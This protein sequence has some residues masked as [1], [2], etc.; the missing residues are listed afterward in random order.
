MSTP[1]DDT[2][3]QVALRIRPQNA[4][5][6]IDL[7]HICTSVT[8]GH[9]QVVLGKDKAFTYDFV[10]D[11]DSHQE[12]IY[13]EIAKP[14]IEGCF[15][16]Y[17]ATILAYGQTGS[18]KT[19]TMGTSF[20]VGISE[21]Q[22]GII[23][24]AAK[25]LFD[26]IRKRK[27]E[28][29]KAGQP[30]PEFTVTAQFLE[31]YN[32]EI[33]D[34]LD[35]ENKGKKLIRVHEDHNGNIYLTGV[36]ARPVTAAETCMTLLEEG[37]ISRS[38]A[39]TMMNATSSR[40]H[41]IFTLFIKHHRISQS[42]EGEEFETLNAKFNFVDLAGSERLKRTGATGDRAKEGISINQGLL[43]LGNVISALGDK[44][45]R[46]SHV[47]YRDSK[48]TRLL[49]DSLGGNS[50]T[51]M[52]ACCSPSDRDFMETLNT[53]KYANRARNIKNKVIVNQDKA[54]KQ[55]AL[56][57]QE[58]QQITLELMEYKQGKRV[59]DGSGEHMSDTFQELNMLRSENE[60][61]RMR[62]KA[63]QKNIESKSIQLTELKISSVLANLTDEEKTTF[64]DMV[65]SYETKI[66]EL[67]TKLAESEEL[68]SVAIRRAQNVSR[69][70]MSPG[71]CQ[72]DEQLVSFIDAAKDHLRAEKN[73]KKHMKKVKKE[74]LFEDSKE[75]LSPESGVVMN[76]DEND[77][78]ENDEKN[79][80]NMVIEINECHIDEED[81]HNE[82]E[83][84]DIA[85]NTDSDNE[86]A[87]NQSLK[88]E[89]AMQNNINDLDTDIT[90]KQKLIDELEHSQQRLTALKQ[91]YEQK[92]ILLQNKI[93]ETE[94]ERD[95][96]LKS[97]GNVDQL[98][99]SKSDE[100]R[101]QYEKKLIAMQKEL[102]KLQ[103]S[104]REHQ[105]LLKAKEQNEQQLKLMRDE[106]NDMKRTKVKLMRAM[107][108]ESTRNKKMESKFNQQ[109]ET[110][111]KENRKKEYELK[112]MKDD[113]KQRDLILKRKQEELNAMR[114]QVKPVSGKVQSSGQTRPNSL[115]TQFQS[116]TN[117]NTTFLVETITTSIPE[118]PPSVLH[119]P[120][121]F[122]SPSKSL[123]SP[124]VSKKAKQKWEILERKLT[125]LAI[126]MKN[127]AQMENDME[128][129]LA[130]RDR[131]SK[132][133]DAARRRKEI[134]EKKNNLEDIKDLNSQLE[135]LEAHLDY[136]QEHVTE[137]QGTIMGME[138]EGEGIN[139]ADVIN[140][141]TL[142]E[143]KYLLEHFYSKSV[144][145]AQEL[146]NKDAAYKEIQIK[147]EAMEKHCEVQQQLLQ[148]ACNLEHGGDI[149]DA[150]DIEEPLPDF[151]VPTTR[152]SRRK[153]A[154]PEE[155]LHP[156][157]KKQENKNDTEENKENIQTIDR[158][159][160]IAETFQL[161]EKTLQK[162]VEL[163]KS[164]KDKKKMP[165]PPAPT[166]LNSQMRSGSLSESIDDDFS[167]VG[168]F[169]RNTKISK[170]AR[171]F[172][173]SSS[174]SNLKAAVA[175]R[176]SSTRGSPINERKIVGDATPSSLL[177]SESNDVFKRLTSNL[178]TEG[179]P[180][181]GQ[182]L[183]SK[184][185]Q[186][187]PE[188]L[189]CMYTATGHNNAVL[190]LDVQDNLMVSGS[191][192]RT[193]KVWDLT[194]NEEIL[195]LNQ[196][197]RDVGV[198][199]FSPLRNVIFTVYQSTIKL[200]DLRKGSVI[201]TLGSGLLQSMSDASIMDLGLNSQGTVLYS[202][203]GNI[204]KMIDL[205]TY[206]TIGKLTGHTGA[207][208]CL[209]V[210]ET[211]HNHDNII[212]GSKDH[213]IKIFE[214]VDDVSSSQMPR[215]NL[216]PPHYDGVQSLAMKDKYL[217]SGSRDNTIKRWN[218]TNH[219]LEEHLTAAHKDWV[220]ALNFIPN[221]NILISSDRRGV[222]KLWNAN[223]CK[224]AGEMLAHGKSINAIKCDESRIFTASSDRLIRIWKPSPVLLEDLSSKEEQEQAS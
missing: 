196:H 173:K 178:P 143:S 215:Q 113:K 171:P 198:V 16:G 191:K 114:K 90:I 82:E 94:S 40:S 163:E 135:G 134:A 111:L 7:C 51:L 126:R 53:L 214:V 222:V 10:F 147:L 43:S 84:D 42:D 77:E 165:P 75:K 221:E 107:R 219:R 133:L 223:T 24:R 167:S 177:E 15:D 142:T 180:D 72:E 162:L 35:I 156:K 124:A 203:I 14:L 155:L 25:H 182:I 183:P 2:S 83:D 56:L 96:V 62:V 47:P 122:E 201:K 189:V 175:K 44:T 59:A 179:D 200:W 63:L 131:V 37:A 12:D 216:E 39:A 204:V 152:K 150:D 139:T 172:V 3:V 109:M 19:Y 46:G 60:T 36:V 4:S 50:R 79:E 149:L 127:V 64:K 138:D 29:E 137:S 160:E 38:T 110:M 21:D 168:N 49:Q 106:L 32:E 71:T 88:N 208:T 95:K 188:V 132:Q 197:K 218:F 86:D 206:S 69:A 118:T 194:Q 148:H 100:V 144:E 176:P 166:Q 211:G 99:R 6:K 89:E 181:L 97:I 164:L 195:S 48:L 185:S 205:R 65:T 154:L 33:V 136:I 212:T 145:M 102:S 27:E 187:K 13:K 18:G 161:D 209:L 151:N 55:I 125:D 54:S 119:D 20:D 140:T 28:A 169:S 22:I 76:S 34:L 159:K 128:R 57:R 23:P 103:N 158:K 123:R 58:I 207:V 112:K 210:A 157:E 26:G 116:A 220:T 217:F 153:T 192:D 81:S 93:K 120:S 80:N 108:D 67:T 11:L 52:I 9:P 170:S 68:S 174:T 5:E 74:I 8:P 17:N 85:S 73:K 66:Q 193:A 70:A 199:K 61:L 186:G 105:R 41:A 117:L 1:S 184:V 129:W 190:S 224:L 130:E 115:Q 101:K 78:D 31:L 141:C 146:A 92:M 98:A 87:L 213:S 121:R 104:K 45:K 91:Q 202:A 30:S